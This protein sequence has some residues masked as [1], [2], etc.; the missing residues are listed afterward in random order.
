MFD[1]QLA[2][3]RGFAGYPL[4]VANWGVSCP[5]LPPAWRTWKAWQWSATGSVPGIAGAT[6]LDVF[7]GGI[8]QLASWAGAGPDCV[9]GDG[10]YCGG[11]GVVGDPR[12]LFR[13]TSGAASIAKVCA[14][15]CMI[16]PAGQDDACAPTTFCPAG[17]GAYCGGDLIG[18]DR[19]TLYDCTGGKVTVKQQC[20]SSCTWAAFGSDD[21][22]T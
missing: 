21:Q 16:A 5:D 11:N 9:F 10:L 19:N 8:K 20:T 3:P 6:D 2:S 18:G 7:N 17:D 1:A 12:T 15:G 13:C 22:C 4:F 14:E